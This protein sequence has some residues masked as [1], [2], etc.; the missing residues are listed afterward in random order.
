MP[1]LASRERRHAASPCTDGC[2]DPIIIAL[3]TK[4]VEGAGF[5]VVQA[6]VD[7]RRNVRVFV[8][9]ET[10]G[11]KVQDCT[12]LTRRIRDTFEADGLE[13]GSFHIEVLSPGLDR[14]LV[15]ERD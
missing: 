8:D 12:T 11:V 4:A 2:M 9:H 7:G 10:E 6:K 14:L 5:E 1:R 15:R 3:V 13:P